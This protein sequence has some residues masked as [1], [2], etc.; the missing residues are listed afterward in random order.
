MGGDSG[1]FGEEEEIHRRARRDRREEDRGREERKSRK[2][3]FKTRI[4]LIM[5][6]KYFLSL[7]LC[8]LCVLCGESLLLL[9]HRFPRQARDPLDDP[10]GRQGGG[11]RALAG[12]DGVADE[13]EAGAEGVGGDG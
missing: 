11:H 5:N 3:E 1:R 7:P 4:L 9:S 8:G 6:L 2:K 13:P 10:D 12:E